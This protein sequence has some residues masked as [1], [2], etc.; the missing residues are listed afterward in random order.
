MIPK[1]RSPVLTEIWT[2]ISNHLLNSSTCI[3]NRHLK[4]NMSKWTLDRLLRTHT[5]TYPPRADTQ[6][7][8]FPRFPVLVSGTHTH[9]VAAQIYNLGII[10]ACF[11]FLMLRL[12]A[13]SK[14]YHLHLQNK[15]RVWPVPGVLLPAPPKLSLAFVQ[16][17]YYNSPLTGLSFLPPWSLFSTQ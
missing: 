15:S 7:C 16:I 6:L 9:I 17:I 10:L 4:R 11:L 14:Y 1:F 12:E 5:H 8:P 13:L 3:L 2:H